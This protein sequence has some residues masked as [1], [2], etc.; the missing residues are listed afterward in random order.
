MLGK[1]WLDR[2]TDRQAATQAT[3]IFLAEEIR[4]SLLSGDISAQSAS[5]TELFISWTG[6]QSLIYVTVSGTVG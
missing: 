5:I 4:Q 2:Q 1:L 6:L 3:S